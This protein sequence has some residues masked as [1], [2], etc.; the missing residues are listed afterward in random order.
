MKRRMAVMM[1]AI[2]LLVAL[3]AVAAAQSS[4]T[5]A[6]LGTIVDAQGG[7][8]PGVTITARNL[9]TGVV[10]TDVTT[11]TGTYRLRAV[12]PGRYEITA[13]LS[14]FQTNIRTGVVLTVG[15]EASID[16][17][18]ELAGLTET[19]VVEANAPIVDTTN[20]TIGANLETKQIELLPTISRD[21]R[22]FLRVVAG[23][24]D[25][26]AGISFLGARAASNNWQLDGVD[27]TANSSGAQ[28]SSPQIDT[29]AEFQ[30]L[31]NTFK[32]E[33]GRAAG[34]VVNAITRSGT[35]AYHGSLFTYYRDERFRA[36]SPFDDQSVP[37][38]P[39]ERLYTGGTLGGPLKQNRAFFFGAYERLGQ[40]SNREATWV[41]PSANAPFTPNM[42]R[43]FDIWGIDRSLFG[44]GGQQRFVTAVPA[45]SHKGSVRIDWELGGGQ[46]INGRYAYSGSRSSFNRT[47]TLFDLTAQSVTSDDHDFNFN[48]KWVLSGTKL[49]EFYVAYSSS[50]SSNENDF[51]MPVIEVLGA[52]GSYPDLLGGNANYP[53][54]VDATYLQIKDHFLWSLPGH[55]LKFGGEYK[56]LRSDNIVQNFWKGYYIF[57]NL[58]LFQLGIPVV[59][60]QQFGNPNIPL[61]DNIFGAFVQDDW[62]P[63]RNLTLSVGL[64]YDYQKAPLPS[65][66]GSVDYGGLL[67]T[68]GGEDAAIGRDKNNVAPRFG[69]VWAPSA[70]QAFY[71]GTGIYYDQVIL[72]NYV[73]ALFTP[74]YRGMYTMSMPPFPDPITTAPPAVSPNIGYLASDF[75]APWAWS[76]SIGYRRELTPHVGIDMSFNYKRGEAQQMQINRNPGIEGTGNLTGSGYVRPIPTVGNANEYNNNGYSRYH[77]LRVELKRRMHN[78]FSGG[79]A[80]TLAKS[81][82]N[83]FNQI[84]RI[85]VPT[86]PELNY[87]PSDYDIR[88]QVV[89]HLT[90]ELPLGFQAAGI[91]EIRSP[92]PLDITTTYDLNGDGITGDWVN[93]KVCINAAC[94]GFNYSRNSVR[95]LSLEEA[96]ALRALF[97]LSPITAF[98]NNPT[99]W[100]VDFTLRKAFTFRGHSVSV[101]A[102]AFNLF[103]T[104]QYTLP[105]RVINSELF[106]K[107]T[108]VVQP[109]TVQVG[110]HYRF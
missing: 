84:S 15:S 22:S 60:V 45:T 85:Q 62:R 78:R 92:R 100:N 55:E 81:E 98:E 29:I 108:S 94:P 19:I 39:F 61:D 26:S 1:A 35:N 66:G 25:T 41:L 110:V 97:G 20:A 33:Y 46:S 32:A 31:T 101:A 80:Y 28:R 5:A 8:L 36:Y 71:G 54:Y 6:V 58:Q 68:G 24:S 105:N 4:D 14:G 63:T 67:P 75:R 72:N 12:P 90:V 44:A 37:K 43:F 99:F 53:Q 16:F 77:G 10:R 107:Y 86:H 23:T 21:Y 38:T 13:E 9:E 87:G 82:D 52:I 73:S 64:R 49:N 91:L 88:H 18:L 76:S 102:E 11:E 96:N 95:S 56:L 30:V 57:P 65:L 42:L 51:D 83:S 40:E 93:E 109:R 79:V 48:H 34:G 2:G 69:F 47:G 106:G 17:T 104:R 27:N 7:V 3:P 59:N 89:S 74:P 70:T 50:S 103:N